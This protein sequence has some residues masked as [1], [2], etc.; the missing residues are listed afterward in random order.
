VNTDQ[1]PP[2][3]L[4]DERQAR[5]AA[6]LTEAQAGDLGALDA[7]VQEL[8]P[9]LWH[10]ARSQGLTAEDAAD[11]V[12]TTWLELVRK[13][14]EIRSPRALTAW[15]VTTTKREA[16]HTGAR[17]RRH[18]GPGIEF[19]REVAADLPE[20]DEGLI[21]LERHRALRRNFALLSDRCRALLRVIAR[22]DR[23]D[24]ATIA[25]A[26]G[27]AQGSIGPTRGRCLDKLRAMLVA[28]PAWRV[29]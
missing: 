20:P 12:Q 26:L 29:E 1:S 21:T 28:D 5:L 27:M 8:N 4:D 16:W 22:V 23:P 17:R 14:R 25:E 15:L 11:V 18:N 24:Y 6:R 9:L 19:L 3:V 7:V 10:V 2:A 13:L